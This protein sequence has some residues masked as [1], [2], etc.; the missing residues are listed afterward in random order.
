MKTFL[1]ENTWLNFT[2]TG[3]GNGYVIIPKGHPFHGKSYDDINLDIEVHGGLTFAE[4]AKEIDW[5]CIDKKD[6]DGWVVGFDTAHYDD[7]P[8]RWTKEAVQSETDRLVEQ[9]KNHK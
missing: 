9:L 8:D 2:T 4:P 3:W 7:N 6:K 1:R 5:E